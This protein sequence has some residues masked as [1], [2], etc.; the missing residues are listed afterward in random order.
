MKPAYLLLA[1]HTIVLGGCAGGL[2]PNQTSFSVTFDP[3]T[4]APGEERTQCVVKRLGNARALK[5]G[6]IHNHLGRASHHLI[7]YRVSD[8]EE[9]ATPFDCKPFRKILDPQAGAPLMVSQREDDDLILPDGVAFALE[10]DQMIRLELHYVNASLTPV[11]VSATSTFGAIPDGVATQDADFLFVG[12]PD[13]ELPPH[14]HATV[15]PSFFATPAVFDDVQFFGVTGHTHSRGTNVTVATMAAAAGP[16]MARVYDVPGWSYAEPAT[17]YARPPF[18]VQAGGGFRFSCDYDNQTDATIRYGE[19]VNAE[20]CIFWAYYYP[21][22]GPHVC[23]TTS[24][25]GDFCC[26]ES[27]DLCQLVS[28]LSN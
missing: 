4:V 14:A 11:E 9:Q 1:L 7:V 25:L 19:S 3:V 13:I 26:P 8:T 17:V 6:T 21:S 10:R 15:G 2:D 16:E 27:A 5:L 28:N 24:L 18:Q 20:M 22:K 23:L 12:T